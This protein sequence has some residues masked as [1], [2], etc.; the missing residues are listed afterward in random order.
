MKRIITARSASSSQ[1]KRSPST[2]LEQAGAQPAAGSNH[3]RPAAHLLQPHVYEAMRLHADLRA[4]I[5]DGLD[6]GPALSAE[7]VFA[8]LDARYAAPGGQPANRAS[9]RST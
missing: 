5:Q 9:N 2:A 1:L 3:N 6:S 8:E 7:D 4:A